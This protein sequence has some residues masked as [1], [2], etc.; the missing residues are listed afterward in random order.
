[1]HNYFEP[2]SKNYVE[3]VLMVIG[4]LLCESQCMYD[5]VHQILSHFLFMP[6]K[7]TTLNG[8]EGVGGNPL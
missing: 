1:M 2:S 4:V 6:Q 7:N 3:L 5:I 8:G